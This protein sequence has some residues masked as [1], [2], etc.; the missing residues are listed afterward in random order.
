MLPLYTKWLTPE[1]YG[2]YDLVLVYTSV[3]V[4]IISMSLAEAIFVIP[5]DKSENEKTNFFSSAVIASL[6]FFAIGTALLFILK[7]IFN[8]K[9]IENVLTRYFWF[10]V[11]IMFFTF[12]QKFTQQFA[13]S[14]ND[15]KTYA[16]SGV[17]L[18]ISLII[19]S[20][21]L[22]PRFGLEGY[23]LSQISSMFISGIFSYVS[24]KAYQYLSISSFTINGLKTLLLY[25]VPLI[26]NGIMWWLVSSLNRPLL[27]QYVGEEGIGFFAVAN[28][29]PSLITLVFNIFM[30]S[31]QI[32]ILEE[33]G[34]DGF[35]HFFNKISGYIIFV[36]ISLACIISIFSEQIFSLAIDDKFHT[37]WLLLP[38]LTISTIFSSISGLSGSVFSA[39]LKSKYYFYSSIWGAGTSVFFNFLLIPKFGLI[40]SCISIVLSFMA[41]AI[42]RIIYSWK[43]V[44]IT[45]LQNL[46]LQI[47]ISF[48][49]VAASTMIKA[50]DVRIIVGGLL[51]ML[52]IAINHAKLNEIYSLTKKFV[53]W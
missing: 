43:Y 21:L 24:S 45:H 40:G 9:G 50:P 20:F 36:I 34:K 51:F 8:I 2:T 49:I 11:G 17:V 22:I 39:V 31:W 23:F 38:I 28:K 25:S 12:S 33:Y 13:R 32:A 44:K 47:L 42:S 48:C 29:F 7:L 10:F 15:I 3:L 6:M 41:M 26:P 53:N 14:L 18:T 30:F 52:L 37:A 27:N 4:S 5:K 16:L 46:V 1:Q 19:T 35:Q